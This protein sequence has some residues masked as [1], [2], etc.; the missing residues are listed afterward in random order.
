MRV[1]PGRF[2]GAFGAVLSG[3]VLATAFLARTNAVL[4]SQIQTTPTGEQA[5]VLQERRERWDRLTAQ[6][7]D[8]AE[9]L[10]LER[11]RQ[12]LEVESATL[13]QARTDFQRASLATMRRAPPELV[14]ARPQPSRIS[15]ETTVQSMIRALADG[16]AGE[17]AGLLYFDPPARTEAENFFASLPPDLRTEYGSPEQLV[18]HVMVAKTSVVTS[19]SSEPTLFLGSDD[20]S[21]RLNIQYASGQARIST[22]RFHRDAEGWK[23]QVPAKVIEGYRARVTGVIFADPASA[24][25][26]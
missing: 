11:D 17:I 10:S 20:A 21:M 25:A 6:R 22:L 7:P 3:F 18:A 16:E 9:Q 24:S 4:R 1:S 19:T 13:E 15:P 8:A 14:P 12:A 26:Q 5:R 23:L 2:L